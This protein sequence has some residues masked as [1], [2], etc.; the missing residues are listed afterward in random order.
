MCTLRVA[1]LLCEVQLLGMHSTS[2]SDYVIAKKYESNFRQWLVK[3]AYQNFRG[4]RNLKHCEANGKGGNFVL[5][6]LFNLM[7][8]LSS[9]AP[10]FMHHAPLFILHR[11]SITC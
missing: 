5:T 2:G 7:S 4:N 11:Y 6:L 3:D 10:P 9:T 8:L 1:L